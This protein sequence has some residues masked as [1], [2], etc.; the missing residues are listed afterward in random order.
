MSDDDD[1]NIIDWER[2]R[3]GRSSAYTEQEKLDAVRR[4]MSPTEQSIDVA[5]DLGIS[6]RTL[7]LWKEKLGHLAT[8]KDGYIPQD[9]FVKGTSTMY[10][11][12]GRS[13]DMGKDYP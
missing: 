3:D 8:K 7:R 5:K 9:H 12:G 6:T 13:P 1:G 10:K 2:A 11:D 4:A